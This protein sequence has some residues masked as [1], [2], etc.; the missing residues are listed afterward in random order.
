MNKPTYADNTGKRW[1][2]EQI[3]RKSDNAAKEKLQDQF[4]DDGYN[5]CSKCY[6]NDCKP[7]DVSHN[8]SKKEAKESN[9]AQ[10]CWDKSNM[11]ILGRGCHQKKDK[12][13]LKF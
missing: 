2:T 4:N 6:R 8:I 7:I 9:E 5:Y 13:N 12:L 3:D 11:E 10:L 1:T